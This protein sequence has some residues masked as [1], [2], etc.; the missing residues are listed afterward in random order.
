MIMSGRS[1]GVLHNLGLSEANLAVETISVLRSGSDSQ[2]SIEN[3]G[4]NLVN[5]GPVLQGKG[6]S[7]LFEFLSGAS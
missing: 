7:E 4:R 5:I 6:Q 2:E 1:P 3:I